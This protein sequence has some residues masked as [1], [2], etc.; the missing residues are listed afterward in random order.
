MLNDSF[1][2]RMT[3]SVQLSLQT[4]T[5]C[6]FHDKPKN[7]LLLS[8]D[9]DTGVRITLP[10]TCETAQYVPVALPVCILHLMQI[11]LLSYLNIILYQGCV[12]VHVDAGQTAG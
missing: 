6:C 11:Y 8:C 1:C 12:V 10:E 4:D 2:D 9:E 5:I 3:N 7:I